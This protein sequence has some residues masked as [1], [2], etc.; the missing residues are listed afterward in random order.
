MNVER[1]IQPELATGLAQQLFGA[2]RAE[3]R[4][5]RIAGARC[6]IEKT[7]TEIPSRIGIIQSSRRARTS[8]MTWGP[9]PLPLLPE[10]GST[11]E[12]SASLL[13]VGE[14]EADDGRVRVQLDPLRRAVA[15]A[16]LLAL[17][18]KIQGS[19]HA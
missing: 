9:H 16:T 6:I 18:M 14:V 1:L 4:L 7:M 15:A 5:G 12:G 3:D 10:A 19:P 8:A 17:N 2:A 13:E 11:G